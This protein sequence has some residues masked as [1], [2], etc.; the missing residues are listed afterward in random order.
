M[1]EET[2]TQETTVTV[3]TGEGETVSPGETVDK[4]IE[5]AETIVETAKEIAGEQE[6]T[7][8]EG[9]KTRSEVWEAAD[10][11]RDQLVSHIDTQFEELRYYI[12]QTAIVETDIIRDAVEDAAEETSE[13]IEEVAE[14]IPAETVEGLEEEEPEPRQKTRPRWL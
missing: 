9:E 5:V 14:E 11:I 2:E 6:E 3:S 7:R 10:A 1:G 13:E 12:T 8:E 4:A